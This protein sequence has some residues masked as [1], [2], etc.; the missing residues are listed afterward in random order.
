MEAERQA[1]KIWQGMNLQ[2]GGD[3][4][5][6]SC[7]GG[8]A[9]GVVRDYEELGFLSGSSERGMQMKVWGSFAVCWRP[10]AP[11]REWKLPGSLPL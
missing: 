3:P 1:G 2:V 9:Q 6:Q 8:T 10:D 5:D 11:P 4:S 7:R